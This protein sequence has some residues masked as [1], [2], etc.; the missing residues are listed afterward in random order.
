MNS[1]CRDAKAGTGFAVCGPTIHQLNSKSDRKRLRH[2][3]G[4]RGVAMLLV[5]L[6]H[7]TAVWTQLPRPQ[8]SAGWFLRLVDADATF[9][10]SF[11]MLIS[12]F[13]AY[14]S[15]QRGRSFTEFLQ[16]RFRRLYPLYFIL[17]MVYIAGSLAIPRMSKLPSD[18]HRIPLFLLENLLML[19]GLFHI[20]PLMDVSWTLSFI[21]AFYFIAAALAALFRRWYVPRIW[22]IIGFSAAGIAWAV[23]GDRFGWW[24]PRTAMF[25]TGMAMC[26]VTGAITTERREWAARM[27]LPAAAIIILGVWARTQLMLSQSATPFVS[28]LVWRAVITSFTLSA[29]LWFCYFG[30][31][32]WEKLMSTDALLKLGTASYS[33]YLTHGFTVKMFRYGII[34]LLGVYAGKAPVFWLSQVAG[35]AL[36]IWTARIA[37]TTIEKP[38]SN[39][40]NV[41]GL[42]KPSFSL[43]GAHRVPETL[44]PA[45]PLSA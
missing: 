6:G 44:R 36:S 25:W 18:P 5:F 12:A 3:D 13:F 16:A 31:Q 8:G 10:S 28:V 35:L 38:L 29:L 22:K 30:P 32:W 43:P 15:L 27:T 37:Y 24:E 26:E 2:V 34:P 23:A 33:F 1:Q 21:I 42:W 41:S 17:S 39:V 40:W 7:F 4:L 20:S 14:G 9:G 45:R 11:F 19:P